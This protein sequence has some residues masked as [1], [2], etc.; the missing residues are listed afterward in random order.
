MNQTT[1]T[2]QEQSELIALVRALEALPFEVP[3]EQ[4]KWV[5]GEVKRAVENGCFETDRHGIKGLHRHLET[6]LVAARELGLGQSSIL[7]ILLYRP[8]LKGICNVER[9][10]EELGHDVAHLMTLL[11]KTSE[12]YA[13][14]TAV[15]SDNFRNL[16]I[17]FAE[18]VRVILIMIADRLVL[19]RLANKN[20]DEDSKMALAMEVSFLYA[21]LAHR[22]GLYNVKSEMEDLCLKYTDRDTFDFIKRKL[23][24]T[25]RS[26]DAYIDAFIS[27]LEERLKKE[28]LKFHIKG[29]TKSISSIRNKLK[30]QQIEFESIYDLFAIRIVLDVPEEKERSACWQVYSIVTDMYRPNP[31]RLKD[32]ISAPK[33]NGYESLHITVMGPDNRWVEVQ[34]RTERMD[35]IAEK[36]VAAHWRYKGIRPE[37]GLDE[38]MKN[39]RILLEDRESKSRE[40]LKEFKMDMYS[41]EIYVFTPK[42]ELI[43]L[44]KGA[45]VLDFAFSIHSDLGLRCTGGSVNGKNVTI[46]HVL[47]NGDSVRIMTASHQEPKSDWLQFVQ[48][49]RARSKIKQSIRERSAKAIEITKEEVARKFKNRKVELDEAL[50]SRLVKKKGYKTSTDFFLDIAEGR[51]E[52]SDVIE[53]Y[54]QFR[55][56]R[57]QTAEGYT[58]KSAESFVT[59]TEPE[60]I[61]RSS[62]V[63]LIDKNLTGIE[64]N[65]AK[66]CNPIYGDSVFAFVSKGGIKIHRMDCPNAPDLFTRYGYRVLK[67]RWTGGTG[68]GY[69]VA[70]KVI[71][72]DD[73]TIVN[74]ITSHIASLGNVTL[75]RFNIDSDDG[76]FSGNFVV[77]LRDLSTLKGLIK[78]LKGIKGVKHVERL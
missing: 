55:D 48:T 24:E 61:S 47:H 58:T 13:R 27:P 62:D 31:G 12:L 64:Y 16:L 76:L 6:A 74:N 22:L 78:S 38:F 28:G 70:L 51:I 44:P 57:S 37:A 69:E 40:L 77:Y 34:I 7:A 35:E 32:W 18:D 43:N 25:K 66:C 14:N 59:T 8:A 39:V 19:L 50:F 68:T 73:V 53:D 11:L 41:E 20:L 60:E 75:K 67:A 36:G 4:R 49:S 10:E 30:K 65:L 26:R 15:N 23:N 54:K 2:P 72:N 42:G 63:L 1:F 21:P 9:V 17:S 71:G 46:K 33:S 29:R 3:R 5:F 45:T 52:I 56:E